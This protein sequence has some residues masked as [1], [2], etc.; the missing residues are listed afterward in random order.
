MLNDQNTRLRQKKTKLFET[1]ICDNFYYTENDN[2]K[3]L[4]ESPPPLS[5]AETCDIKVRYRIFYGK[6]KKDIEI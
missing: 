6:A 2:V 5:W 1:Y 4:L 3:H